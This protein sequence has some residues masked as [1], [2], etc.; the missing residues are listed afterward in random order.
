M[1]IQTLLLYLFTMQPNVGWRLILHLFFTSG[2]MLVTEEI[3]D[4][5]ENIPKTRHCVSHLTLFCVMEGIS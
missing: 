3:P 2:L 4:F 5:M 1:Q